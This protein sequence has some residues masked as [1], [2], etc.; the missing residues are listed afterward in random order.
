MG[1]EEDTARLSCKSSITE[2]IKKEKKE[3]GKERERE[4]KEKER[5]RERERTNGVKRKRGEVGYRDA[6]NQKEKTEKEQD[7]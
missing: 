1:D 4:E 3:T 7:L 2:D 5:E 6:T